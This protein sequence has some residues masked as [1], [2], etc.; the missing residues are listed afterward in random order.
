MRNGGP[1]LLAISSPLHRWALRLPQLHFTLAKLAT[2]TGTAAVAQAH[3]TTT[4]RYLASTAA[5]DYHNPVKLQIALFRMT[6][7]GV[8][9]VAPDGNV[10]L[11]CGGQGKGDRQLKIIVSSAVLSLGSTVFKAM[12]NSKLKEG[13]TLA[14]TSSVEIPLPED[15][16]AALLTLC[17]LLHLH[18]IEHEEQTADHTLQLALLA[19]KYDCCG[20]LRVFYRIWVQKAYDR[21]KDHD[22]SVKLFAACFYMK[23]PTHFQMYGRR[24]LYRAEGAIVLSAAGECAA[25][26]EYV[27]EALTAQRRSWIAEVVR[28]VEKLIK[29]EFEMNVTSDSTHE[30]RHACTYRVDRAKAFGKWLF[31][32]AVWPLSTILKHD[33][34]RL[35]DALQD[36]SP[37]WIGAASLCSGWGG[38]QCC[39]LRMP[40]EKT[41]ATEL[42]AL[43]DKIQHARIELCL[44]CVRSANVQ[45][46]RGCK[47]GH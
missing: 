7:V 3:S 43:S 1:T 9:N 26:L 20:A 12:L 32:S 19:D 37:D 38:K 2:A 27:A 13:T 40:D 10:A 17:K 29:Q 8:V 18:D 4:I 39:G 47:K 16:S 41:L 46:L 25:S 23:L 6:A 5:L 21:T 36:L 30:C 44:E 45:D 34:F 11:I 33:I 42:G 31:T 22:T 28:I 24:L 14:K 35:I 15:D